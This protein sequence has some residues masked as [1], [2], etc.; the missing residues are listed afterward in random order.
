MGKSSILLHINYFATV[1]FHGKVFNKPF[2]QT[3][4]KKKGKKECTLIVE[5]Q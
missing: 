4:K 3:G 2:S 5:V 1:S